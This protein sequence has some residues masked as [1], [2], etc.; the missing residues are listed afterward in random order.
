MDYSL[1]VEPGLSQQ[2]AWSKS[3]Y[4]IEGYTK[5]L[6]SVVR[7]NCSKYIPALYWI[8]FRRFREL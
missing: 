1:P 4:L 3:R 7:F 8:N 2:E 6:S 5:S